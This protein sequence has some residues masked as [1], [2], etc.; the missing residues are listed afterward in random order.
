MNRQVIKEIGTVLTSGHCS[1]NMVF[2]I[3]SLLVANGSAN[4]DMTMEQIDSLL[5]SYFTIKN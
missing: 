2:T 4:E 3:L 1:N 5:R